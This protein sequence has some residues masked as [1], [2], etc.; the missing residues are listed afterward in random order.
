MSFESNVRV[1]RAQ[2]REECFVCEKEI[3]GGEITIG[4]QFNVPVLIS[5]MVVKRL[6]HLECAKEL[7]RVLDDRIRRGSEIERPAPKGR[8]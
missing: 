8:R 1:H 5:T 3:V 4:V 2:M 6:M 7:R